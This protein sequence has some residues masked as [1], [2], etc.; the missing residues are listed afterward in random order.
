MQQ[1][2][3]ALPV[4]APYPADLIPSD[5]ADQG[6]TFLFSQPSANTLMADFIPSTM[7]INVFEVFIYAWG[8][9][10]FFFDMATDLV[11]AQAYYMEGAYWLF[12]LTLLC[13]LVPNLTL[14]LFSLV[15]YIDQSQLKRSINAPSLSTNL[16]DESTA[17]TP[18]RSTKQHFQFSA[19]TAN[20][21]TWMIR[22][23]ILVLQL[24]LCLK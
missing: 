10:A 20:V 15:W 7:T 19:T 16:N 9:L 18:R 2:T 1:Q 22:I 8:V 24:D 6:Q 21:L 5:A 14:S 4:L 12:L 23:V 17:T 13:V 11:L 3:S